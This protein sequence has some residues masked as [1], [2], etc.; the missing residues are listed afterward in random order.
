MDFLNNQLKDCVTNDLK[1]LSKREFFD[2]KPDSEIIV[3]IAFNSF[4]ASFNNFNYQRCPSSQVI[5]RS[6]RHQNRSRE[7]KEPLEGR[8][9]TMNKMEPTP[10]QV[11]QQTPFP[12]LHLII[13][14][15]CREAMI[16]I[17]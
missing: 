12:F 1:R 17:L 13:L 2:W 15:T 14:V 4:R 11:A 7:K 6:G 16:L 3:R 10:C 5:A 9:R 8:I